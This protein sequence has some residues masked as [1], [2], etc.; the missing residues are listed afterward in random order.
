MEHRAAY[1]L[2]SG[3]RAEIRTELV[4]LFLAEQPGTGKGEKRSV[5]IYDVETLENGNTVYLKR[6]ARLNK[7]FDFEVNVANTL[8][9]NKKR[10]SSMPS[11]NVI[12]RDLQVKKKES[13][14]IYDEIRRIID[15]IYECER[16]YDAELRS[17]KSKKGYPPE[18]ICKIIKWLFIEQDITYWNWSGRAMLYS[19]IKKL[20][21]H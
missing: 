13:N 7:G 1:V 2:Q 10:K 12:L 4:K 21:P 19:A 16:I 3:N 17:L 11:H 14:Q 18:L 9:K 8:F 5:Y 20:D 6:P 15:R